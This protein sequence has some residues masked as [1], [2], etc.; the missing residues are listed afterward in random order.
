MSTK[1]IMPSD[2]VRMS[3]DTYREYALSYREISNLMR[4]TS[5][6]TAK[7]VPIPVDVWSG[8]APQRFTAMITQVTGA[9]STVAD[10][11]KIIS[12][13]YANLA[14][15]ASNAN[16]KLKSLEASFRSC[17]S[18]IKDAQKHS[19][20]WSISGAIDLV[21]D[22]LSKSPDELRRSQRQI[23]ATMM[24][25]HEEWQ[26]LDAAMSSDIR[27]R[28]IPV[29]QAALDMLPFKFRTDSTSAIST[30]PNSPGSIRAAE[31]AEA[32]RNEKAGAT[33]AGATTTPSTPG[34]IRALEESARI[35]QEEAASRSAQ[36]KAESASPSGSV[37][38]PGVGTLPT[39]PTTPT[40]R[41][42]AGIPEITRSTVGK[43]GSW[44]VVRG[45]SWWKISE[46]TL[47]QDYGMSPSPT[48]INRYLSELREANPEA[49]NRSLLQGITTIATP[50]PSFHKTDVPGGAAI[51]SMPTSMPSPAASTLGPTT[52]S[53]DAARLAAEA[54]LPESFQA[55]VPAPAP[56]TPGPTTP[57]P[58]AARLAAEAQYSSSTDAPK[59]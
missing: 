23:A 25:V 12:T 18:Q 58:D 59:R 13:Y 3:P 2:R 14:E 34:S 4:K 15:S 17:E 32:I 22:A 53:P 19:G 11:A 21:D 6:D 54:T 50:T 7:I 47:R 46:T 31:A 43:P 55:P 57:S 33:G 48:E 8:E 36:D 27:N 30:P 52:P 28:F 42:S 10:A 24:D 1:V 37:Y 9:A 39:T 40:A 49:A 51:G 5:E 35:K 56:S 20:G 41:G 38:I 26:R 45:D 44:P 16:L 29:L